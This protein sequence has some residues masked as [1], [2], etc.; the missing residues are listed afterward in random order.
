MSFTYW[1]FQFQDQQRFY[2]HKNANII[3][4]NKTR[5]L[6]T[7]T[8][9]TVD[10]V[11]VWCNTLQNRHPFRWCLPAEIGNWAERTLYVVSLHIS[12]LGYRLS[13]IFVSAVSRMSPICTRYED[14]NLSQEID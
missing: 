2:R 14:T 10:S 1:Y 7:N 13:S 3:D 8:V 12:M 6:R 9:A 4:I 5:H 11:T